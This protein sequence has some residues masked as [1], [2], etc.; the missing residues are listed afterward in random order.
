[1]GCAGAFYSWSPINASRLKAPPANP[2]CNLPTAAAII[3]IRRVIRR[4]FRWQPNAI[5]DASTSPATPRA[6]S[7][8]RL[9]IF[10]HPARL[11]YRSLGH[12]QTHSQPAA[13]T[14]GPTRRAPRTTA[15]MSAKPFSRTFH[16]LP[17]RQPA[18]ICAHRTGVHGAAPCPVFHV[19]HAYPLSTPDSHQPN[20]AHPFRCGV[21]ENNP[22]AIRAVVRAYPLNTTSRA[23][24]NP[25]RDQSV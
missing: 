8:L 17:S 13:C 11:A 3:L 21:N 18:G 15:S 4:L 10:R 22:W 14:K 5:S 25:S 23:I 1:M 7:G 12:V 24:A 19:E 20:Y 2:T 16:N 6:M 9:R